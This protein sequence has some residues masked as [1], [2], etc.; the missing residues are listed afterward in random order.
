M[1]TG[2][3]LVCSCTGAKDKSNAVLDC[4]DENSRIILRVIHVQISISV[5]VVMIYRMVT[6]VAMTRHM[7]S[8]NHT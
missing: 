7:V 4:D 2:N 6:G 3:L 1:S 5:H 8:V